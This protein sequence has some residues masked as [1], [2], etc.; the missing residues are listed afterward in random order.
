M[1][2]DFAA[3]ATYRN[4]SVECR[5]DMRGAGANDSDSVKQTMNPSYA[6]TCPLLVV[7]VNQARSRVKTTDN[8]AEMPLLIV[9]EQ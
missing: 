1:H 7:D 6:N 2:M 8:E 4:I 3:K 9:S 5:N